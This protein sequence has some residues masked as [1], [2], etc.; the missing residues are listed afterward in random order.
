MEIGLQSIIQLLKKRK[1]LINICVLN[2]SKM[3]KKPFPVST[4]EHDGINSFFAVGLA[5]FRYLN[6]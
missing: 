6:R 4:T 3:E 1:M 2:L 5:I